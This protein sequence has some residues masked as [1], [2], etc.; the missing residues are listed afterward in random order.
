MRGQIPGA[1]KFLFQPAEEGAPP[2]EEGGAGLMVK[3]GALE[4]PRPLAILGLHVSPELQTG[5]LGYRAG[6]AQASSDVFHI[7]VHGKMA[8]AAS[9]HKGVDTILVAAECVTALQSIAS[10]RLTR[11][12]RWS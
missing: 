10:R 6:P 1:V 12:S 2:G 8:H 4:N 7:T 11:W 9:P 5:Q 3:E